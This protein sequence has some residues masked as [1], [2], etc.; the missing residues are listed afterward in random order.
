MLEK[1]HSKVFHMGKGVKGVQGVE[2][3]Y[4]FVIAM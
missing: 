4:C 1:C 2:N 3:G